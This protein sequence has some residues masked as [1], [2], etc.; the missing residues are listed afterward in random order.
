MQA[1]KWFGRIP[2]PPPMIPCWYSY[3]EPNITIP[4]PTLI[5]VPNR[6]AAQL[7][8]RSQRV[9]VLLQQQSM[10]F[11]SGP[12]SVA[13]SATRLRPVFPPQGP[14]ECR[15]RRKNAIYARIYARKP[16]NKV[17]LNASRTLKRRVPGCLGM[18]WIS[19]ELFL[20]ICNS[21]FIA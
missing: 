9:H 2:Y 5:P 7:A 17:R 6:H 12:A 18:S 21:V 20:F 13:R 16:R 15:R 14:P 8:R 1:G 11:N 10:A 4:A 3:N 19:N